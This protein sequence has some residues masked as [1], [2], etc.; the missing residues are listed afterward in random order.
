MSGRDGSSGNIVW[1][2]D[3]QS[4]EDDQTIISYELQ[5][6]LS[7]AEWSGNIVSVSNAAHYSLSAPLAGQTYEARVRSINS[8]GTGAWSETVIRMAVDSVVP[9]GTI[10]AYAGD[11]TTPPMDWLR[12]DGAAHSRTGEA[13]LYARIGTTYGAGDGSTTFNVPEGRGRFLYGKRDSDAL[14][15]TG[16]AETI[17]LTIAQMPT[18]SHA[19][20]SHTHTLPSHSHSI[21]SHSHGYSQMRSREI[22]WSDDGPGR[23]TAFLGRWA[24]VPNTVQRTSGGYA[25]TSGDSGGGSTGSSSMSIED[26]GSG[27]SHPN[28]PPYLAINFLIRRR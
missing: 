18:H 3:V 13:A 24:V 27:Q 11:W 22:N 12:C 21:P 5:W 26:A 4:D 8:V 9:V 14:G 2:W 10:I 23:Y 16:G 19:G 28:M 7:T 15:A 6:R 25:G 1:S 20:P 17:T